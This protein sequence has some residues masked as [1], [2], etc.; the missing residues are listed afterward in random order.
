MM[1][2]AESIAFSYG[3]ESRWGQYI[4][5]RENGKTDARKWKSFPIK[6]WY[7]GTHRVLGVVSYP[8]S[9]RLGFCE[10]DIGIYRK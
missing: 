8:L 3:N 10:M 6:E 7:S 4:I 1:T 2:P 5:P 9:R